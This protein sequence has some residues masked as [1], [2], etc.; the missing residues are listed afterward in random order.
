MSEL[1]KT[2]EE[3][4]AEVHAELEEAKA[5]GASGGK[6]DSM[7]KQEGEVEDLAKAVDDPESK[8]SIGKKAAAKVS[9][10]Q[11]MRWH[12]RRL[13]NSS[14]KSFINPANALAPA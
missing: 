10:V 8:E 7:E 4:E 9:K 13:A 12:P 14:I 1:D 6:S 2:I 5:P 11:L 3:L